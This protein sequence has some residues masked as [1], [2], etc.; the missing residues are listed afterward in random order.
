[1]ASDAKPP[2]LKLQQARRALPSPNRPGQYMTCAEEATE[3]N[4]LLHARGILDQDVD[5]TYIA[6]LEAGE[7]HWVRNPDRRWAIRTTLRAETD[8]EIGFYRHRASK[9]EK[10]GERITRS[11]ANNTESRMVDPPDHLAGEDVR[12]RLDAEP[13][14]FPALVTHPSEAAVADVSPDGSF[15]EDPADILERIQDVSSRLDDG[16]LRALAWFVKDVEDRYETEGPKSIGP[17]VVRQRGSLQRAL[18][19]W[20]TPHQRVQALR[21]ASQMSGQLSYMAVNLGNF[22][23]ARAYGHEAFFLADQIKDSDLRAWIRGTQSFAEFY[24]GR[25]TDALELADDGS[26]YAASGVQAIRLAVNGRARALAQLGDRSAVDRAVGEAEEMLANHPAGSGMTPCISFGV[27]SEARVASNAITAYVPLG[28]KEIVLRYAERTTSIVDQSLSAW[29]RALV[30]LD[31]ATALLD[32]AR[33]EL[34]QAAFVLR[35]AMQTGG[36]CRIES[37]RQRTRTVISKMEP[38][39]D[40]KEV[41]ESIVEAQL[42]ISRAQEQAPRDRH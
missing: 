42:W 15:L 20:M 35:E 4:R 22:S 6:K 13:L 5:A 10:A 1:M 3:V 30:R 37:I 11:V 17:K 21:L 24:A 12:S 7:Y 2:N 34:E 40:N 32:P 18:R 29:S 9:K 19:D 36:T 25:Y 31:V 16:Y 38:H 27:Y 23:A 26:K 14:W 33:P 8:E 41:A 28:E 39:A